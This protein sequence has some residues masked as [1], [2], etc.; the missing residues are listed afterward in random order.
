[1]CL[2]VVE[3]FLLVVEVL[4]FV[5]EFVRLVGD[6]DRAGVDQILQVALE[7]VEFFV[8]QVVQVDPCDACLDHVDPVGSI[9][10]D[11]HRIDLI[12]VGCCHLVGSDR[13]K[14]SAQPAPH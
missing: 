10:S 13:F 1:M 9:R 2:C 11:C 12:R 7:F 8:G 3:C 14:G 6:L 4:L 5:C